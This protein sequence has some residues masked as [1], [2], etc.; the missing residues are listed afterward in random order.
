MA[1]T[2]LALSTL[3]QQCLQPSPKEG[4]EEE[5]KANV[6][7]VKRTGPVVA[8]GIWQKLIGVRPQICQEFCPG[9]Y[10]LSVA[11]DCVNW[12]FGKRKNQESS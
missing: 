2:T 10:I 7:G 1:P 5:V 6:T 11:L 9:Q 4:E 3:T 8:W 12:G